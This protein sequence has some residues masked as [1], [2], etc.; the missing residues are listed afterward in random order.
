[1][2]TCLS[3][4]EAARKPFSDLSSSLW[5]Q[6]RARSRSGRMPFRFVQ[7]NPGSTSQGLNL[8]GGEKAAFP[9]T[10]LI[11]N[12]MAVPSRAP[13]CTGVHL[14][15]PVGACAFSDGGSSPRP[16]DC[17]T[18]QLTG[19]SLYIF[20]FWL[21]GLFAET[22]SHSVTLAGVQWLDLSSLDLPRLRRSSHLTCHVAGTTGAHHHAWLVFHH[23]DWDPPSAFCLFVS[24]G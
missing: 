18:L 24:F 19:H 22:G 21:V 10:G 4:H 23:A 9:V 3:L 17:L 1:M 5:F 20:F 2:R 16:G 6:E 8:K 14:C 7:N 13:S 11:L 15:T 12:S